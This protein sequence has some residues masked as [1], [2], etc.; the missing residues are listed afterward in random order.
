MAKTIIDSNALI[1]VFSE[2]TAKQGE[3]LRKTVQDSVLQA[4]KGR[5]LSLQ[6]I[7]SVLKTVTTAASAG[8]AKNPAAPLEIEAMLKKA[9]DGMDAALLQ[10][11]EAHRRAL[12]QFVEHRRALE[13]FI[14]HGADLRE[15]QL[16]AVLGHLEKIEDTFLSTLN[17]VA[18]GEHGPLQKMWAHVIDG[19]LNFRGNYD[20]EPV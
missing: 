11:V 15:K 5:E 8:A 18:E 3:T 10:T 16:K 19:R 20:S 6:N 9:V 2:A 4:L 12:E 13:Q 14:E 17:Q 7:R 1:K